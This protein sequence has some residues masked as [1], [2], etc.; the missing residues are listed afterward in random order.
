MTWSYLRI[1]GLPWVRVKPKMTWTYLGIWSYTGIIVV[2]DMILPGCI[3][4]GL[5]VTGAGLQH[6]LFLLHPSAYRS[7]YP[8]HWS[9]EWMH[10]PPFVVHVSIV[11]ALE[12]G[13]PIEDKLKEFC[14][15]K[16]KLYNTHP[17][18]SYNYHW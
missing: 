10:D 1:Q 18:I 5:A 3:G 11:D 2:D 7:I 17:F 12:W 13:F 8:P 6:T 4:S 16:T 15:S 9:C 14:V